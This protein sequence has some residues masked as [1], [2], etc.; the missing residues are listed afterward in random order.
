MIDLLAKLIGILGQFGA[1]WLSYL[2]AKRQDEAA[3]LAKEVE[4]QNAIGEALAAAPH[5]QSDALRRLRGG[6]F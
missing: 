3:A 2:L 4:K 1:A 6:S 5:D